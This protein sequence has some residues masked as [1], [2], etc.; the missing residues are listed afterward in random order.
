MSAKNS[1]APIASQHFTFLDGLR[2]AAAT[3]VVV[4]HLPAFFSLPVLVSQLGFGNPWVAIFIALSGFCLY[5]PSSGR[6]NLEMPRPFYE[7]MQRRVR[8]IMPAWY[9]SLF[10]CIMIGILFRY[11]GYTSPYAFLP[12]DVFDVLTHVTLTHSMSLYSGS[13][14]GPGY[15]LGTEWQLYLLMAPFLLIARRIGWA[16]LLV[17]VGLTAFIPYPLLAKIITKIISPTFTVPFILGM[18]GSRALSRNP[19]ETKDCLWQRRVA[20][21][22][23]LTGIGGYATLASRNHD[24][25]CWFIGVATAAACFYMAASPQALGTLFFSSRP[26]HWLG[27]CSYSLY[28]THFALLA[29]LQYVAVTIGLHNQNTACLVLIP[30]LP[31]VFGFAYVFYCG[32][33]RPFLYSKRKQLSRTPLTAPSSPIATS[34]VPE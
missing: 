3:M 27:C 30:G 28:L 22:L 31:L 9:A 1:E 19:V 2:G 8:R 4:N 33:E 13:I 11:R 10:L 20:L 18:I 25:A 12:K 29:L 24:I 34:A 23:I 15:T 5:L 26:L 14:N 6:E 16:G 7:F 32:F 17:L 21:A